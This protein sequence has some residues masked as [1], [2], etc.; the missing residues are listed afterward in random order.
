VTLRSEQTRSRILDAAELLYA[1]RGVD[2]VSLREIRLASGQR[3]SSALQYHFGDADGVLG[4]LTQRH[5]PRL[6]ELHERIK[7]EL[8]PEGSAPPPGVLLETMVR[9]WA[10]YIT[11]GRPARAWIRIAAETSARPERVWTD[12]WEHAPAGLVETGAALLEQ[13]E[14]TLGPRLALDR[15]TRVNLA[16]LHLC[17]DRSR[18]ANSAEG[19]EL[20]LLAHDD[21]AADLV[22]TSVAALLTPRTPPSKRS[23]PVEPQFIEERIQEIED[24]EAVGSAAVVE[25]VRDG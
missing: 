22:A 9:P 21:W 4:A 16:A 12:F 1:E 14:G 23:A 5:M 13:L 15:M 10:D 17:A 20:L 7:A 6:G 2:G 3:N 11:H 8:V 25:T 19:S 18:Q 24:R